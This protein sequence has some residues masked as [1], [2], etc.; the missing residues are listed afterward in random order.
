MK[1]FFIYLFSKVM[2][3]FYDSR[4]FFVCFGESISASS[5]RPN[6]LKHQSLEQR[7]FYGRATQG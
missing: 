6:K 2:V 5:V 3:L 4:V 7:M 1:M